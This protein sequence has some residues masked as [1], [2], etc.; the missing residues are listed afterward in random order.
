ME[1]QELYQ[2]IELQPEI[3]EKLKQSEKEVDLFSIK[4]QLDGLMDIQSA[5]LAYE[6]LRE[7]FQD[8]K[9]HIKMLYCQLECAR[10]IY[11]RYREKNIPHVYFTDTMKCFSR[12]IAECGKKNGSFLFDRGWWTYRQIS[13]NLFR[14]GELEYQFREYEGENVIALHIPSDADFSKERV[15]ASLEEAS[16]FFRRFYSEYKYDK[17]I[18]NSWLLSQELSPFLS[19]KSN[20]RDFQQRFDIVKE[21]REDREFIEWLF[22]KPVDTS[23]GELPEITGLQKKIKRLLLNNGT[24]GSACGI[25]KKK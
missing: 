19:E 14:I 13:M 18:C 24:V 11:A 21:S 25:M 2:W 5:P 1:L 10:R 15:D 8:D 9:E 7:L 17:Y 22:Q 6:S 3:I 23:Y 12:F 16:D 4:E 20:I